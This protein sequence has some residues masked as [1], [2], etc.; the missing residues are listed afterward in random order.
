MH[1]IALLQWL[2]I[3]IHI[4]TSHAAGEGTRNAIAALLVVA[5][6][7]L[8]MAPGRMLRS[9]LAEHASVCHVTCPIKIPTDSGR[10]AACRK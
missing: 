5:L 6:S 10:P 8:Y 3:G 2:R 1:P 4:P 9:T 7:I